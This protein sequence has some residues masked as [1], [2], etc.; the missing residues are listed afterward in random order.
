MTMQKKMTYEQAMMRLEQIV[1]DIE[2]NKLQLDQLTAQL[3]EA[4]AIIK[5]CNQQLQ[6]VETDV[7]KILD[8]EQEQTS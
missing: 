2:Q 6:Q 3:S 1:S 4:Q 5:L 8:N 7:Q